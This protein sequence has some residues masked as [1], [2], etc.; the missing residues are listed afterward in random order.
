MLKNQNLYLTD[1]EL[2]LVNGGAKTLDEADDTEMAHGGMKLIIDG[3]VV[4]L[5]NDGDS[6]FRCTIH[7]IEYKFSNEEVAEL[8][9]ENMSA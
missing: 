6:G 3:E 2:K 1:N 5:Y 4:I 7:G 9:H 8:L